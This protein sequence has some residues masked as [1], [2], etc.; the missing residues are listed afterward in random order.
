MAGVQGGVT[1]DPYRLRTLECLEDL[2]IVSTV[3]SD[4]FGEDLAEEEDERER[5]VFE[6]ARDY[7]IEHAEDGPVANAGAYSRELTVPGG[8]VPA[9]HVTLVGVRQ[10]HRR[11]GLLTRMML[12]QLDDVRSAG[13]EP[14]AVLWASEA[15]IY[16][17]FGYGMAA[18]RQLYEIKNREVRLTRSVT[19]AVGRLRDVPPEQARKELEQVYERVRPTRPGWSSRDDGWW[20]VRLFD[21]KALRPAG[22]TALRALLFEGPEG[23]EG[24]ALWRRKDGGDQFGPDAEVSVTELV[25]ATRRP[26]RRCGSSCSRLTSAGPSGTGWRPRTSRCGT[27][28]T[29]RGLC[30][31]ATRTRCGSASSICPPRWSPGATPRRSTSCSR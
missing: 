18:G 23:V 11:R 5:F 19:P 10:T 13:R 6:P 15:R 12:H 25:A 27:W 1:T 22:H 29:S 7:V 21:H 4:A 16:Q 20:S 3:L 24:Y 28:S 9:A 26:T 14:V 17:R 30:A 8:T 2:S 31:P